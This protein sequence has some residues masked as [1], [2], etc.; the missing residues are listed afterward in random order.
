M[1]GTTEVDE[2]WAAGLEAQ[3]CGAQVLLGDRSS[4][5]GFCVCNFCCVFCCLEDHI[6]LCIFRR[7]TVYPPLHLVIATVF[8]QVRELDSHIEPWP[9]EHE[10]LSF[11]PSYTDLLATCT[12]MF[13]SGRRPARSVTRPVC[14]VKRP[15]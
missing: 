6:T 12:C 1:D 10:D 2:I 5:V 4:K 13:A 8:V 3:A 15:V 11:H 14:C 7:L 9:K